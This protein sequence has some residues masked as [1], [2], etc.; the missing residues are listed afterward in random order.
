MDE[1]ICR[2]CGGHLEEKLVTRLQQYQGRWILIENVPALIC[3]QC[4]EQYYT[5]DSH[6]LVV[7]IITGD[8]KPVRTEEV[9][10][11][12]AALGIAS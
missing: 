8:S 12:D 10:V 2:N 6:D 3:S 7:S 11:Y 9:A 1:L 4:G 5:P